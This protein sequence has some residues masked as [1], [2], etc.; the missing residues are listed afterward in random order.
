M[1]I[2]GNESLEEVS[3]KGFRTNQ[4]VRTE[5]QYTKAPTSTKDGDMINKSKNAERTYAE[6]VKGNNNKDHMSKGSLSK[7]IQLG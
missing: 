4:G 5:Y 6:V 2:N 1:N 3:E 7:I